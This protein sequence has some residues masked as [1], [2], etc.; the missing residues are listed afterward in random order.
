MDTPFADFN[1]DSF[2]KASHFNPFS[3]ESNAVPPATP[4][5]PLKSGGSARSRSSSVGGV[6]GIQVM[7]NYVVAPTVRVREVSITSDDEG[8]REGDS[9]EREGQA[10]RPVRPPSA[11]LLGLDGQSGEE[12]QTRGEDHPRGFSWGNSSE[13]SFV[14]R[15][16]GDVMWSYEVGSSVGGSEEEEL[17]GEGAEASEGLEARERSDSGGGGRPPLGSQKKR[18]HRKSSASS[19]SSATGSG[20]PL[21]QIP[22]GVTV[23]QHRAPGSVSSQEREEEEEYGGTI[24]VQSEDAVQELLTKHLGLESGKGGSS[25]ISPPQSPDGSGAANSSAVQRLRNDSMTSTRSSRDSP[26]QIEESAEPEPE[27]LLAPA[28]EEEE[29]DAQEGI[30]TVKPTARRVPDLAVQAD[31]GDVSPDNSS[32]DNEEKEQ[33]TGAGGESGSGSA[34][35]GGGGAGRS[36]KGDEDDED[37]ASVDLNVEIEDSDDDSSGNDSASSSSSSSEMEDWQATG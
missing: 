29:Q 36:S 17:D 2:D 20:P 3:E 9:S 15:G 12:A 19:V 25:T 8:D 33:G 5:D 6:S 1:S 37:T 31:T 21:S 28:A 11:D 22:E 34:K 13:G 35:S 30:E 24:E 14:V 32:D 4:P 26:S 27:D 18:K 10:P 7:E 16:G 23:H